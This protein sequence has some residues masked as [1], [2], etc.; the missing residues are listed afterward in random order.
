MW[1]YNTKRLAWSANVT[2]PDAESDNSN[3]A[4]R[5]DCGTETPAKPRAAVTTE[6]VV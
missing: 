1:R 6:A 2:V 4:K 5:E 3:K